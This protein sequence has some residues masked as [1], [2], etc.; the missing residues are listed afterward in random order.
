VEAHRVEERG[1][2]A[3][4]LRLRI[5]CGACGFD[6]ETAEQD[7]RLA[8]VCAEGAPTPGEEVA[9]APEGKT[10]KTKEVKKT[11]EEKKTKENKKT[12][13]EKKAKEEKKKKATPPSSK[14]DEGEDEDEDDDVEWFTDLSP[15]AIEARRVEALG[16]RALE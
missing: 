9:A 5:G 3:D 14:K 7:A 2:R 8:K 4:D 6:G 13:E 15:E 16:G 1:E 11:K 12:K 10:K